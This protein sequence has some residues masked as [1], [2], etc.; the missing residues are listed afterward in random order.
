MHC[1]VI[2]SND[3]DAF[4][5]NGNAF[6]KDFGGGQVL[7]MRDFGTYELAPPPES[8]WAAPEDSDDSDWD[9]ETLSFFE[10]DEEESELSGNPMMP[11]YEQVDAVISTF[12]KE[13][14][15][16]ED[17]TVM[18]RLKGLKWL[19]TQGT[20]LPS[21]VQRILVMDASD[22]K[23]LPIS[24]EDPNLP[25]G[26]DVEEFWR[27]ENRKSTRILLRY[28]GNA[29]AAA[30]ASAAA[31]AAQAAAEAA[32]MA[33]EAVD[34]CDA[35]MAAEA[36]I[37][38]QQAALAQ[39]EFL[40]NEVLEMQDLKEKFSNLGVD[41]ETVRGGEPIDVMNHLGERSGFKSVVWRA[42]CW[43]ERGVKSILN[44]AFQWVS[45]HLAVDAAGGKFWQL[46]LAERCVQGAC[47]PER[48]VKIFAE[49]E[50][51]SL[52]YCDDETAE[53]DCVLTVDGKPIRHVRLDCRV[54]LVD[55]SKTKVQKKIPVQTMKPKFVEE[56]APWFL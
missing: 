4:A 49:N 19:A 22:L 45:A 5:R 2:N 34:S 6:G 29:L 24:N 50:D 18:A 44:G 41:I 25:P 8:I 15:G 48:K 28:S 55:E 16:H 31:S 56:E 35:E 36:A 26:V 54:A 32:Q 33:R 40:Q 13:G 53:Q 42:G 7:S 9:T 46:M 38:C 51:I 14:N 43:G 10:E 23:S 3:A 12:P 11:W 21:S 39:A 17:D 30:A 52:E 47:G 37:A 20:T 27:A 1:S